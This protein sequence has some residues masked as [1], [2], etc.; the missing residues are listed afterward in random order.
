MPDTALYTWPGRRNAA[1]RWLTLLA[2][3]GAL[4]ATAQ[5]TPPGGAASAPPATPAATEPAENLYA[6]Q[7]RTGPAW[8]S[9]KPPQEQKF[10]REHSAHLKALRDQGHIVLG[11]RYADVGLVVLQAASRQQAEA[12]MAQDPS[13]QH[14]TFSHQVHDFNVFYGGSV[15]P[16][17]RR[18]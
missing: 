9:S 7:I 4:P 8:D 5:P 3:L 1:L 12:L 13:M 11:A 6:V 17:R 18:P 10:F 2:A 15:Q 16:R 14:G